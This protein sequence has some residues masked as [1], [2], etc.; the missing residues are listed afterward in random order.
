MDKKGNIKTVLIRG[1]QP[2]GV[3]IDEEGG[4]RR[5]FQSTPIFLLI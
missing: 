1:E 2:K 4:K 3:S 5:Y